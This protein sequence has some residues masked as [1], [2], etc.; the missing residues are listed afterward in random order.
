[1]EWVNIVAVAGPLAPLVQVVNIVEQG[2]GHV[3][4]V[5]Q[6]PTKAVLAKQA[7]TSAQLELIL[8]E[9]PRPVLLVLLERTTLLLA[10][11][12]ALLVLLESTLVLA[13][14]IVTPVPQEHTLKHVGLA[15]I[16]VLLDGIPKQVLL[17]PTVAM[18][19]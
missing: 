18:Q 5:P 9:V 15:V 7:A 1:V 13:G 12:L 16:A 11:P 8:V 17:E 6:E 2:G 19:R 14:V 10:N 3:V 4:R